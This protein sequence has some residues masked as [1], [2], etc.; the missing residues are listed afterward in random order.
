VPLS[1]PVEQP[2]NLIFVTLT[3]YNGDPWVLAFWMFQVVVAA[4]AEWVI[5]ILCLTNSDRLS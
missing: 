2:N 5:F 3:L 1:D 4:T